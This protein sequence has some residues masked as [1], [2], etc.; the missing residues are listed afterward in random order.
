[1]EFIIRK[2]DYTNSRLIYR[3]LRTLCFLKSDYPDFFYWYTKKVVG[4]LMNDSRQ[5]FI[6]TPADYGDTIVA[7]MILKNCSDEKKVSTLCVMEQY[8]SLGL[9]T[10]L[11]K[12]AISILKTNKPVITVS[13]THV[14]TFKGLLEKF[15]FEHYKEYPD[16]YRNG[17]SEHA[18]NGYLGCTDGKMCVEKAG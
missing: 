14:E 13:N 2:V 4:G 7:V 17:T 16:Y 6:V 15:G 8:R 18:Y 5:I 11:I 3:V 12:I 1:M 10:K 9:G